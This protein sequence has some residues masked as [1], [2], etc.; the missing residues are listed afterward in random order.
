MRRRLTGLLV[1]GICLMALAAMSGR[2]ATLLSI[3]PCGREREQSLASDKTRLTL[4]HMPYPDA[5]RGLTSASIRRG[6]ERLGSRLGEPG[7]RSERE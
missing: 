6:R 4:D 5:P 3:T 2:I 7:S 1:I